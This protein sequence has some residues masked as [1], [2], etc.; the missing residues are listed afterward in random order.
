MVN[1]HVMLEFVF[2]ALV[3]VIVHHQRHTPDREKNAGPHGDPDLVLQ[4][5]HTGADDR[6]D[7]P[8]PLCPCE[9]QLILSAR[10]API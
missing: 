2:M 9:E 3:C 6:F 5:A 1:D 4:R 7:L 10:L 8:T